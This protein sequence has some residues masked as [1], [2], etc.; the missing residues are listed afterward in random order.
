[1]D[2]RRRWV[3]SARPA[4]IGLARS[5]SFDRFAPGCLTARKPGQLHPPAWM[6]GVYSDR[7]SALKEN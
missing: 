2:H 4:M 1:M 5:E 7:R 3:M 6:G